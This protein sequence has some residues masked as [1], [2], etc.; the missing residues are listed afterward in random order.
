M[1]P[2][3][4][5]YFV[6]DHEAFAF[7]GVEPRELRVRLLHDTAEGAFAT[8]LE[9]WARKS[10][11]DDA[12]MAC[13]T[14]D[15][16]DRPV[17]L[18]MEKFVTAENHVLGAKRGQNR[19][20]IACLHRAC[21]DF[22][23][24]DCKPMGRFVFQCDDDP[25]NL[26]WQITTRGFNS[27]ENLLGCLR[28]ASQRGSLVGRSF[29]L[30]IEFEHRGTNRFPVLSLVE[31]LGYNRDVPDTASARVLVNAAIRAKGG[32]PEEESWVRW[33]ESVGGYE[34]AMRQLERMD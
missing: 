33:L 7:A 9:W 22:V 8:S 3:S 19:V 4:L 11:S 12:F 1:L 10:G 16:G 29:L 14:Q 31:T 20:P 15:E 6:S 17:A 28:V 21:P 34:N 32:D 5:D 13:Y 2:V 26:I 25:A 27:I 24:G 23:R 30:T 18:R